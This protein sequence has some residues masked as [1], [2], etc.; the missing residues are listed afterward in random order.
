VRQRSATAGQRGA[1][2]Q[3]AGRAKG[4]VGALPSC[5]GSRPSAGSGTSVEARRARLSGR[6]GAA[7][8]ASTGASS[9]SNRS[10][11]SGEHRGKAGHE[12]RQQ[13]QEH[14]PE[15]RHAVPERMPPTMMTGARRARA[16]SFAADAGRRHRRA[17]RQHVAEADLDV[18][19]TGGG[20]GSGEKDE[21]ERVGSELHDN[22]ARLPSDR[23]ERTPQHAPRGNSRS[24][25]QTEPALENA[26]L[27]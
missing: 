25:W 2:A 11:R 22:G 15:E 1:K 4:A 16:A 7:T 21:G 8:R 27:A 6:R 13:D 9:T 3:P 19:R 5:G 20:A 24:L 10:L 14:H 23:A 26:G 18:R 17:V 12:V